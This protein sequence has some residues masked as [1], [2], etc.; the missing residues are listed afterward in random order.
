MAVGL[1]STSAIV[2]APE[3]GAVD[4]SAPP[5]LEMKFGRVA[6]HSAVEGHEMPVSPPGELD[7]WRTVHAPEPP[8]GSVLLTM[9]PTASVARH[10]D[11]DGHEMPVKRLLP[12]TSS[13]VQAAELPVGSVDTTT[14]PVLVAATHRLTEGHEIACSDGEFASWANVHEPAPAAG[15]VDL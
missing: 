3:T 4:T 2:H 5:G 14:P 12:S 13:V 11:S 1:L 9:S 10:S 15:S 8:V 7:T 6:R